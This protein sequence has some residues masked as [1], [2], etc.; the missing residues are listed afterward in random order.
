MKTMG[1]GVGRAGYP[2][3]EKFDYEDDKLEALK[4]MRVAQELDLN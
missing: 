1:K 4:V 3:M 2:G